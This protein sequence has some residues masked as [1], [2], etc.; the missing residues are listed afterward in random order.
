VDLSI[1]VVSWNTRE[2]LL[3]CLASIEREILGGSAVP[4]LALETLVVDNGSEDGSA[5]AAR[6]GFPWVEVIA[7]S[8]NLGFS[9]G[10]NV[11][12]RRAK[13]R[14]VLLL[15]SDTVVL[16]G[17]VERCVA[18]L[19]AH[20]D[21]GIVGPQL[22]HPDGRLQNSIHAH[23]RL[24]TELGPRGVLETLLPGRF[25]SKR[26]HHAEPI[27]VPAV[28]GAAFFVRRSV[29]EEVGLLSEDYFLF[30]E[31]T[32]YCLR[33]LQAGYRVVHVP[34]A[35]IVHVFGASSKKRL[36]AETRI[37]YQRSLLLFFRKH[38]GPLATALLLALRAAK[39]LLYVVV[40]APGALVSRR[41]RE[42]WDQDRRVLAWYLQG[43]PADWGIRGRRRV[44]GED[45][46]PGL[47]GSA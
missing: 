28:L 44:G 6:D 5:E 39:A 1:V 45:P 11:G 30:L 19:D 12:L 16:A 18:Y 34:D 36:P 26:F 32:D 9:G 29:L 46:A 43:R 4:R 2:L 25:P 37:E 8:E 20:P 14:H 15:N 3:A 35:R 40:R 13:G 31:E 33:V 7:L 17:A 22:L 42:R 38:R 21:V 27:D 24:L 23:P 10:C 41:L 47:G